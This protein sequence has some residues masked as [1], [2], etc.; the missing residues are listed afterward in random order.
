MPFFIKA[1]SLAL[2]KYPELNSLLDSS[3][4]YLIVK[5]AHNIGVAMDTANGLVVPNIKNV[6]NLSV[7]EIAGQLNNLQNLGAKGQLGLDHLKDGT[8]TLS[9]IGSIGGTYTKPIIFSPQ[10]IIGALGK[11]QVS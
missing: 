9:N 7:I 3:N 5:A 4:E 8:F 11:V 6:Q 2:L 10:V 1:A